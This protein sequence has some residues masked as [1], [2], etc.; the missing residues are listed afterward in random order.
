MKRGRGS[1]G[2]ENRPD[3][4]GERLV[5]LFAAAGHGGERGCDGRWE[6]VAGRGAE[7]GRGKC[8][9]ISSLRT[10][11]RECVRG[12]RAQFRLTEYAVR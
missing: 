6:R 3:G 10:R 11:K 12:G 5:G 4:G 8:A 2:A 1:R 7:H 9:P